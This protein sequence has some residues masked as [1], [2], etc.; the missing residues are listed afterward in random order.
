M[1]ILLTHENNTRILHDIPGLNKM[2]TYKK[3]TLIM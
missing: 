2:N 3:E 1:N